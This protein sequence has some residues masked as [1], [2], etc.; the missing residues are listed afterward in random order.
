MET[1]LN[2]SFLFSGTTAEA[3]REALAMDTEVSTKKK[4]THA[5]TLYNCNTPEVLGDLQ[6][7]QLHSP[8]HKPDRHTK[9]L[10]EL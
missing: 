10:T 9:N 7:E 2:L 4:A 5:P 6:M 3:R 8:V 1:S